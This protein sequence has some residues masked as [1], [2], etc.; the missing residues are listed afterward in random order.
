VRGSSRLAT[1]SNTRS[2]AVIARTARGAPKDREF[3]AQDDDFEFLKLLRPSA[4]SDNSSS[5]RSDT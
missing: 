2:P 1:A 4:Q 5:Q 3:V